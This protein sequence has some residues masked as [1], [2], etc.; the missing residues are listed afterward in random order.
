M[1]AH[2]QPPS[3]IGVTG[4]TRVTPVTKSP[5]SLAFTPVTQL[6]DVPYIRCNAAQAC[7]AK[8]SAQALQAD[9]FRPSQPSDL[10]WLRLSSAGRGTLGYMGS[11]TLGND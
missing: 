4:V 1:R 7:N 5:V 3:K 8:V 11:E 2:T 6:R 9:A 10:R